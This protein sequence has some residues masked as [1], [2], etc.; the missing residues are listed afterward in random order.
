M[1][2]HISFGAIEY[3]E[4][5]SKPQDTY[6]KLSN[7]QVKESGSQEQ[8]PASGQNF[9]VDEPFVVLGVTKQ[10]T[11]E[12]EAEDN[13]RNSDKNKQEMQY[14]GVG[15]SCAVWIEGLGLVKDFMAS[16]DLNECVEALLMKRPKA[17]PQLATSV[18]M[19]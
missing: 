4:P 11:A 14:I 15:K 2:K 10:V 9:A 3:A 12:V 7:I 18:Q 16:D 6:F 1:H 8:D 19:R 13:D 5:E 17:A